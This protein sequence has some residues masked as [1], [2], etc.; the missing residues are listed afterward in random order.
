MP[1][2][3][4]VEGCPNGS[5]LY[6]GRQTHSAQCIDRGSRAPL[7]VSTLLKKYESSNTSEFEDFE[8]ELHALFAR[9]RSLKCYQYQ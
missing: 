6:A 3:N 9:A 2:Q 4:T 1:I 7:R 8:R 5:I